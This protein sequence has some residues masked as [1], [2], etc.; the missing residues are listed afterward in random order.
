MSNSDGKRINW[1]KNKALFL[2]L[3]VRKVY[4]DQLDATVQNILQLVTPAVH[5]DSQIHLN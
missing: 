1:S 2:H 4:S 3:M 5:C